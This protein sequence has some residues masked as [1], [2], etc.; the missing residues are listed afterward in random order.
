MSLCVLRISDHFNASVDDKVWAQS[1]NPARTSVS[2]LRMW[3]G[4]RSQVGVKIM[5]V[6]GRLAGLQSLQQQPSVHHYYYERVG[7]KT[8]HV[9]VGDRY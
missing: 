6:R 4:S 5:R 2:C 8:K 9:V 3:I 1:E 7:R